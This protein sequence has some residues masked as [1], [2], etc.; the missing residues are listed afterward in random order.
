MITQIVPQRTRSTSSTNTQWRI[1]YR[2]HAGPPLGSDNFEN[3]FCKKFFCRS[4]I[5][6]TF[7][8][9]RGICQV[10]HPS[11]FD[12]ATGI[13]TP[14]L[15]EQCDDLSRPESIFDAADLVVKIHDL[16]SARDPRKNYQKV[17]NATVTHQNLVPR[18]SIFVAAPRRINRFGV[19]ALSKRMRPI[20]FSD[21]SNDF[22]RRAA[23]KAWLVP[24][25]G[26]FADLDKIFLQKIFLKLSDPSGGPACKR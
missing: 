24:K 17:F 9:L 26:V 1:Y 6:S 5:S 15:D 25:I 20:D 3:I 14:S 8:G 10:W 12:R 23:T 4:S 21:K 22:I 11:S 7:R 18:H 13:F 19:I 2:L 16:V